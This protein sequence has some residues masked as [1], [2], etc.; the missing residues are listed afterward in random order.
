MAW[1]RLDDAF[2]DHPKIVAAGPL[3]GWLHICGLLYS[4]RLLTDGFIPTGQVR[5]LADVENALELAQQLCQAGLWEPCDGG[6]QIHDY[7]EYNP[8]RE[9]TLR[10]RES[11]RQRKAGNPPCIEEDSSATPTGIRTESARNPDGIE[12]DS[13]RPRARNP[14]P[15]PVPIPVPHTPP[16]RETETPPSSQSLARAVPKP[17][18]VARADPLW[19]AVA[20]LCGKPLTKSERSDFGETISQ[21]RHAGATPEQIPDFG[22]WWWREYPEATLTHRC[23]RG[24]WGKYLTAPPRPVLVTDLSPALQAIYTTDLSDI[25]EAEH[26]RDSVPRPNGHSA[27]V[28]ANPRGHA[29]GVAA[30]DPDVSRGP[31]PLPGGS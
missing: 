20:A 17:G 12:T 9:E 16:E 14:V 23:L 2:A 26:G 22:P 24:H 31:Q 19:D 7:L 18:V 5:K 29:A 4:A 25:L 11:D 10:K 27:L 15:H 30:P 3:A 8:S 1:L 13:K 28:S 21:L 6:Y